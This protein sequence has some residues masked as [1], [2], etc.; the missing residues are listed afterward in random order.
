MKEDVR[1]YVQKCVRCQ[2]VKSST[3]K[4]AGL[5]HPLTAPSPGYTITLDF[6]KDLSS[7]S[8]ATGEEYGRKRVPRGTDL[9]GTCRA[10]GVAPF[11]AA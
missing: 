8:G 2:K 4:A 5:L 11:V 10:N 6:C 3:R 9:C 1:E 7:A